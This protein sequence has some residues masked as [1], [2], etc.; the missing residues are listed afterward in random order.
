MWVNENH[1]WLLKKKKPYVLLR[2]ISLLQVWKRKAE[3][4]LAESGVPYTII[5][6]DLSICVCLWR[7]DFLSICCF[8]VDPPS[9]SKL[10]HKKSSCNELFAFG[11][12]VCH[13]LTYCNPHLTGMCHW[14]EK[15]KK[16]KRLP[17]T[18]NTID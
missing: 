18:H 15:E 7:H 17:S 14:E 16:K 11:L 1:W 12:F 10:L 13:N 2:L 6:Y 9:Y 5:R 3:Q 8:Y 4:Y